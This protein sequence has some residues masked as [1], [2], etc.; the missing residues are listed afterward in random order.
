MCHHARPSS[1][2][3]PTFN[4]QSTGTTVSP[5]SS[6]PVSNSNLSPPPHPICMHR[7]RAQQSY[8][9]PASEAPRARHLI[10]HPKSQKRTTRHLSADSCL[11]DVRD[12]QQRRS[13]IG[14]GPLRDVHHTVYN[15]DIQ[16]TK[17]QNR[18]PADAVCSGIRVAHPDAPC[19]MPLQYLQTRRVHIHSKDERTST[20]RPSQL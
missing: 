5:C 14:R 2:Y 17:E 19:A 8:I 13:T 9:H 7:R 3:T 10:Y 1:F 16:H 18:Y 15:S 4:T 11:G 6:S 20:T 12:L